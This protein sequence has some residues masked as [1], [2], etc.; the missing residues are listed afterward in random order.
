MTGYK[1]KQLALNNLYK[2]FSH[3]TGER[4]VVQHQDGSWFVRF[5]TTNVGPRGLEPGLVLINGKLGSEAAFL[6]SEDIFL[7]KYLGVA[8]DDKGD[9]NTW[10]EWF[11]RGFESDG[12]PVEGITQTEA[13]AYALGYL[14]QLE[15]EA[16]QLELS[17]E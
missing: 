4:T 13:R 9:Y 17:G 1:T 3:C 14:R 11:T 12:S 5:G 8:V 2:H 15:N 6:M 7:Q 16:E 10:S